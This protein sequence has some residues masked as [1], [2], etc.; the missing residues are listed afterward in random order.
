ML[1]HKVLI[2]VIGLWSLAATAQVPVVEAGT[3]A[4]SRGGQQT[5]APANDLVLTLY[6]QLEALQQEVQTLRGLV[7][8]QSNQIRRLQ[9]EQLNRYVD[10][11]RRLSELSGTAVTVPP[12]VILGAGTIAPGPGPERGALVTPPLGNY[13]QVPGQTL[14]PDIR[15]NAMPTP[16]VT[17]PAAAGVQI[18]D[19]QINEQDLYRNALNLLLEQSQYE[20]SIRQFQSYIDRFP[21]GRYLTNAYY[22]QGEALILVTRLNEARDVFLKL[23]SSYP[24]DPK[25]PGAMLKLGVVYRRMG[26]E[27]LAQQTWREIATK[28]PENTTEI[29]EAQDY[30]SQPQ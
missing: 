30:L 8:E 14:P 10:I 15:N 27:A 26:N 25:T 1:K 18:A 29:R 16:G 13:P 2:L 6:N 7:E 19:S 17:N 20:E 9:T 28:Y 3:N 11:D 22:W 4:A 24:E 5:Q 23:T 12:A 21:Q